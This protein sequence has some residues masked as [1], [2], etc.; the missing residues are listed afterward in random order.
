LAALTSTSK[1]G[2][3]VLKKSF[4]LPLSQPHFHTRAFRSRAPFLI[5]D[6]EKVPDALANVRKIARARGFRSVVT[7]PLLR[8]RVISKS[9]SREEDRH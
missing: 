9:A 8:E 3:K 4:P 5:S 2:D 1:R 6:T 7:V